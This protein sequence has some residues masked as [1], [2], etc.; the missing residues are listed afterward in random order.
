L[1]MGGRSTAEERDAARRITLQIPDEDHETDRIITVKKVN[2]DELEPEEERLNALKKVDPLL[3]ET[4][5]NTTFSKD[6]VNIK[7]ISAK[8]AVSL[9]QKLQQYFNEDGIKV[10]NAQNN[11]GGKMRHV[12][13]CMKDSSLQ[14]T[15]RE[16]A[17]LVAFEKSVQTNVTILQNA[18][19]STKAQLPIVLYKIEQISIQLGKWEE[20]LNKPPPPLPPM[21]AN[22]K[23]RTNSRSQKQLISPRQLREELQQ[24]QQFE[25]KKLDQLLH[26]PLPPL[27]EWRVKIEEDGH[28]E[29][30]KEKMEKEQPETKKSEI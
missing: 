15:Q 22:A 7:P 14:E 8:A 6:L 20:N 23:F 5:D 3:A 13:Q 4:K 19:S 26:Q 28:K 27:P 1:R 25:L 17:E 9:C 18:I 2:S 12:E 11:L 29:P 16:V 30:E 24:Q 10:S 21:P